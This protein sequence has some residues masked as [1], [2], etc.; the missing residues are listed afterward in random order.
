MLSPG[1]RKWFELTGVV[2][3]GVYLVV[4][5]LTYS[6][7]LVGASNFGIAPSTSSAFWLSDLLLLWLPLLVH[8]ALGVRLSFGPLEQER[9]ERN[10]GLLL[11]V[12]GLLSLLFLV[13]HAIWLKWPLLSGVLWPSDVSERL[14]ATFS[15]TWHGVPLTAAWHLLGLAVV[16]AHFGWGLGRFLERW[17]ILRETLARPAAGWVAALLFCVGAVT[18]IELAT[19][20]FVPRL[21]R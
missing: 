4:H 6:R 17:G 8:A 2:P 3:L 18:V 20:S 12:T 9:P 13:A 19:G 11:R 21:M 16:T 5:V 10:R 14:M 7:A 15:T 1:L